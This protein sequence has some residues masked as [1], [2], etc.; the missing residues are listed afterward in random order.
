MTELLQQ[1]PVFIKA[2]AM[3]VKRAKQT[4]KQKSSKNA[5]PIFLILDDDAQRKQIENDLTKEG[6]KVH[7][8]FTAREFLLDRVA[9]NNGVV[10]AGYRLREVNGVELI[11][12]LKSDG[13][14][15]PV[16][17]LTGHADVPKIVKAEIPNFIVNPTD[18]DIFLEAIDRAIEGE[19]FTDSEL[20]D[21]FKRLTNRELEIVEAI[22]EGQ[23]S[24]EVGQNLGIST[25]TVEAHRARIMDKTRANDVGELVRLRRAWKG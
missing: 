7:P 15:L 2:D 23:S 4:A 13:I 18:V 11:E 25:K 20:H 16:I 3:A 9:K 17:L 21:A 5:T 10:I 12:Q 14:N 8:Y 22:C 1:F 19:H 6:F 24:R